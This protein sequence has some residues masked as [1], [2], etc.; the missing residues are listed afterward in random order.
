MNCSRDLASRR[1][2]AP[3]VALP[4]ERARYLDTEVDVHWL[5]PA[6]CVVIEEQVMSRAQFAIRFQ[7][8]PCLIERWF[9]CSGDISDRHSGP[10]RCHQLCLCSF[11]HNFVF[12]WHGFFH[13][14]T[15][16]IRDCMINCNRCLTANWPIT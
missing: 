1:L 2:D 8:S 4:F 10:D 13:M 15:A 16:K 6:F 3:D 11:H 5:I 9:P 14:G 7:E 12:H